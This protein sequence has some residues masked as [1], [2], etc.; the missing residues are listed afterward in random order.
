MRSHTDIIDK[1]PTLSAYASD[2]GVAYVTA[3]VMRYRG[4]I[5]VRHWDAVVDAALKRGWQDVTH[6]LLSRTK[7]KAPIKHPKQRAEA[8]IA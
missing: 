4:S 7:P 5:H 2:I 8:R 6:E 3:Q 1:W